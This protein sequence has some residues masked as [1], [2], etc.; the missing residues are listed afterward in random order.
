VFPFRSVSHKWHPSQ[1]K[2]DKVCTSVFK[3][4]EMFQLIFDRKW[5]KKG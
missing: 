1:K 5:Q 3:K 4:G 2:P